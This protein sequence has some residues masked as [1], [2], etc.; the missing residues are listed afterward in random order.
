LGF[1]PG[2]KC[3]EWLYR[4]NFFK[5]FV[6]KGSWIRAIIGISAYLETK[7]QGANFCFMRY[8]NGF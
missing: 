7:L 2:G 6:I 1:S 3:T 8:I 4:Y 5:H